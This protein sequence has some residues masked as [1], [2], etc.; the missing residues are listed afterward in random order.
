M[1]MWLRTL[2]KNCFDFT[3]ADRSLYWYVWKTTSEKTKAVFALLWSLRNYKIVEKP[4]NSWCVWKYRC[5]SERHRTTASLFF[6]PESATRKI[7]LFFC[8]D[9]ARVLPFWGNELCPDSQWCRWLGSVP[10]RRAH[11]GVGISPLWLA[12]RK[13]S[14]L[15]YISPS[16]AFF[17][18]LSSKRTA[19]VLILSFAG[20]PMKLN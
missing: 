20:L 12:L 17:L 15:C 9:C 6:V 8:A 7:C 14:L 1:V 5:L 10:M 11:R 18:S 2:R 16:A 13:N 19:F 4:P 3:F